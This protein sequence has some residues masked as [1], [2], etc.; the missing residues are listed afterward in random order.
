VT[1]S[2]AVFGDHTPHSA[3]IAAARFSALRLGEGG[4]HIGGE[5]AGKS[6]LLPEEN[7]LSL[8]RCV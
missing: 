4:Q 8:A 7:F 2:P 5:K 3:L 1:L 6:R